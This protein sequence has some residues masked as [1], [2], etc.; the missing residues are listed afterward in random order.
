MASLLVLTSPRATEDPWSYIRSSLVA[1]DEHDPPLS[2]RVIVCDG[3]YGGPRPPGWQI[4]E[5]ER[6]PGSLHGRNK[7]PYWHLLERARELG[8][9]AVCLEDDLSFCLNAVRRMASFLVPADL[10]WVQFFSPLHFTPTMFPGLW[11]PPAWSHLFLQAAKFPHRTLVELVDWQTEPDFQKFGE[12]DS[13][14]NLVATRKGWKYGAHCP[15]LV[16][17][18]GIVSVANEGASMYDRR[19]RCF[20]G[21][22]FDALQCWKNDLIYR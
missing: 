18:E 6:P 12:S 13:A 14:L 3:Q 9:D 15:D 22:N 10:A 2:H 20:P 4:V 17:H 11:R 19:A 7:L 16:Q 5:Y 21:P 1:I 8:H